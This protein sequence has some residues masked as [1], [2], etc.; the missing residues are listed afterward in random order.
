MEVAT[1]SA[2]LLPFTA[3]SVGVARRRLI[4]DL[5]EAGV[6]EATACDAGLVISELISNALR[7]ASPLPGCVVKV[8]WKLLQDSVEVE[9]SD[10]GGPTTP[11][12]NEP[13]NWAIG[14][15]GLGIVARLSLHWGVRAEEGDDDG[16]PET[17]VWAELPIRYGSKTGLVTASSRDA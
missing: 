14:G 5:T 17:T 2:L 6:Y 4:G 15:R 10:G 13:T 7:H 1:S 16:E 12:V 9:V 11:A 3:S 8:S